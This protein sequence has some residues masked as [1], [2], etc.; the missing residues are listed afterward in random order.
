[1]RLNVVSA[2]GFDVKSNS[3]VTMKSSWQKTSFLTSS[4][5]AV[6]QYTS[7]AQDYLGHL[8]LPLGAQFSPIDTAA[9]PAKWAL[10]LPELRF[11]SISVRYAY[12][13]IYDACAELFLRQC[14]AFV[15]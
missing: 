2:P 10:Q 1:M 5:D 12:N 14:S 11:V 6:N 13:S 9:Q 8:H 7:N 3:V 15:H 4:T